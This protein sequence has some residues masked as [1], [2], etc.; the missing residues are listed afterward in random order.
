MTVIDLKE[1][2]IPSDIRR[3]LDNP[4]V[5]YQP[6][7]LRSSES[8]KTASMAE[9]IS[10]YEGYVPAALVYCFQYRDGMDKYRQVIDVK[11]D[12]LPAE[13]RYIIKEE[14]RRRL[15]LPKARLLGLTTND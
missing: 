6:P 14:V 8:L 1:M 9:I 12:F 10:I 4:T 11:L 3:L 13:G 7:S 5:S 2:Y 15:K